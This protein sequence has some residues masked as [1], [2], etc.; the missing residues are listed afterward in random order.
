MPRIRT[1]K[2]EFFPSLSEQG[3]PLGARVLFAGMLTE[4]DDDGRMIDSP[5]MLAGAVFPYD[6][7]ITARRVDGWLGVLEQRES[8]VRYEANGKKCIALTNWHKHQRISHASPSRLPGPPPELLPNDSGVGTEGVRPDLGSGS[9]KGNRDLG[10]LSK[11]SPKDSS[12]AP[13][14]VGDALNRIAEREVVAAKQAGTLPRSEA[15][16]RKHKL[17]EA[18][19]HY[20]MT[21]A[22]LV[23][24][25]PSLT[26][27]ELDGILTN[28]AT[29]NGYYS[30]R[31]RA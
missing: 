29:A 14:V 1:I 22:R 30:Q 9:R 2:P 3:V 15:G 16:F 19:A 25:D 28:A 17:A 23:S 26:A 18:Q 6:D 7:D 31:S 10:V 12:M 11:S 4:A 27:R 13:D 5:K 24:E 8:I 21:A 20:G